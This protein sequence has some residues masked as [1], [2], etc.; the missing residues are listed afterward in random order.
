[1]SDSLADRLRQKA[2][3]QRSEEESAQNR[4][5]FQKRVNNYISD[6]AQPEYEKFLALLQQN[7]GEVNQHIGDLPPFQWQGMMIQQGNCI[8]SLH[9]SK[10]FTNGPNN[11]LKIGIGTHPYAQYFSEADRPS[12]VLL[13]M[14]AA[15]SDNLDGIVWVGDAGELSTEQLVEY[16]LEN[17]TEYYLEH[18]PRS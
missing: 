11:E 1:M 12:P 2:E 13:S 17:L 4:V 5:D 10:P 6:H 7:I 16:V 8:A 14:Q 9:F 15:A 3:A 18:K